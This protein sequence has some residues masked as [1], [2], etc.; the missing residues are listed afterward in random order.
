[1][2]AALIGGSG[3]GGLVV[4]GKLLVES[5]SKRWTEDYELATMGDAASN[6]AA[7]G[8]LRAGSPSPPRTSGAL[9]K[10]HGVAPKLR[11]SPS[12]FR[13]LCRVLVVPTV[14]VRLGGHR[15]MRAPGPT[16][17]CGCRPTQSH[18]C[19]A[20]MAVGRRQKEPEMFSTAS[21]TA[22]SGDA[23]APLPASRPRWCRTCRAA[24]SRPASTYS[25][26]GA[27]RCSHRLCPRHEPWSALSRRH[28]RSVTGR[29]RRQCRS[30][31]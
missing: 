20:S 8:V 19:N 28:R 30:L 14:D 24:L 9:L 6:C 21:L 12:A 17:R 29:G 3:R 18:G 5:W 22:T 1:M 15:G 23:T 10:H 11:V 27:W 7:E 4:A 2:S 16:G 13:L 26:L 25:G 31:S